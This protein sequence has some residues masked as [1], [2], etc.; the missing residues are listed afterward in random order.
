MLI[1]D[2]W[3]AIKVCKKYGIRWNPFRS[4]ENASFW[5][6]WDDSGKIVESKIHMN[7]F[8]PHFLE[9]FMHEVGHLTLHRRGVIDK[10]Y[11]DAEVNCIESGTQPMRLGSRL[12]LPLLVEESLASR[13]SRKALKGRADTNYL[14]K[15]FQSYCCSGYSAKWKDAETTV[16]LTDTVEKCIRRIEK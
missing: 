7:P 10:I 6:R 9:T 2:W 16:K 8:Y 12:L 3:Y 13:F 1:K 4:F 14:V 5:A 11:D 15:C